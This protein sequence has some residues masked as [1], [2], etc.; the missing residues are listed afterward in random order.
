MHHR[1][2]LSAGVIFCF[3][4]CGCGQKG[5]LYLPDQPA[6]QAK[7]KDTTQAKPKK[8]T[9]APSPSTQ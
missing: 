9:N 4:L 6:A 2:T 7:Q 5:P 1:F 8:D 3:L